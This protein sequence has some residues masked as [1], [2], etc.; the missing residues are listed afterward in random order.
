MRA[1]RT[2]CRIAAL[3]TQHPQRHALD[4][5]GRCRICLCCCRRDRISL[6]VRTHRDRLT[7]VEIGLTAS[8]PRYRERLHS[9]T[10]PPTTLVYTPQVQREL[11]STFILRRIPGTPRG[12]V[13]AG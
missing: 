12:P 9:R 5:L 4:S 6:F 11:D 10:S 2:R 3:P 1:V 13:Q 7:A 8:Y